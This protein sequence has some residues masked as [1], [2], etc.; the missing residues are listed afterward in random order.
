LD[1]N[2]NLRR[3]CLFCFDL[4]LPEGFIPTPADGE[5]EGFELH[6]VE[7]VLNKVI[8]GGDGGYKPNCNLVLIDFF[9]RY[10][11]RFID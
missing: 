7:W 10:S 8:E 4:E 6:T 2:G 9:I 11:K 3:D 1:E 5:V